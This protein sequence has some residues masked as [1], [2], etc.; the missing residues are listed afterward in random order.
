[1]EKL[2]LKLWRPFLPITIPQGE[3]YLRMS[4][5]GK[6]T[7]AD[8]PRIIFPFGMERIAITKLYTASQGEYL[9]IRHRSGEKLIKPGPCSYYENPIDDETVHWKKAEELKSSEAM[10]IYREDAKGVT[11]R[12]II[13]GPCVYVPETANEYIHNFSWHGTLPNEKPA[14]NGEEPIHVKTPNALQFNRLRTMPAQLY[15]DVLNV[16]TNDDAL[17]TVRLMLFLELKDINKMLDQT[18]DPIADFINAAQSD[19]I[20]FASNQSFEEFK[21]NSSQLNGLN[22]FSSLKETCNRIGYLL[23]NVVHRGYVS[24]ARLQE[25]HD[26]AIESRTALVLERETEQQKQELAQFKLVKE[27][28]RVEGELQL[29]TQKA[30]HKLQLAKAAHDQQMEQQ[31]VVFTMESKHYKILSELGVNVTEVM[32]AQLQKPDRFLRIENK[33]ATNVPN[34]LQVESKL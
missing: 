4:F 3:R 33:S 2:A 1:M 16:R 21:A 14:V 25:M 9:Q 27:K 19:V 5:T 24:N 31:S 12:H 11:S 26:R 29:E 18:N 28:E 17:L 34:V 10:V 7:F 6:V 30:T 23:G 32:V 15:L 8:G 22:Q 20:R 13:V